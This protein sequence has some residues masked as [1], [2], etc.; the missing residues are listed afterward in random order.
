M[1]LGPKTTDILMEALLRKIDTVTGFEDLSRENIENL[2]KSRYDRFGDPIEL[3]AMD[4]NQWEQFCEDILEAY[5]NYRENPRARHQL[6]EDL[7][8]TGSKFK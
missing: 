8:C 5:S 6:I 7:Y 2:L 4:A 3:N 1:N